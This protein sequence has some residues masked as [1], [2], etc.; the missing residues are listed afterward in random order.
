MT[1]NDYGLRLYNG[2]SGVVVARDDG[3]VAAVFERDGGL[4][5][6]S[7]AR[8]AASQTVYAMTIHRSQGSQF[9]AVAVLLPD[10]GVADP[11]ARAALHGRHARAARGRRRRHRGRAAGGA[12]AGRPRG[13]RGS[14]A[15][16]RGPD[17]SRP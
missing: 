2:D 10:G 6:V 14:G 16:W 4:V 11:D 8:L 7:P 1:Q 9:D 17:L 13:R 3:S 5:A 15:R 12:R